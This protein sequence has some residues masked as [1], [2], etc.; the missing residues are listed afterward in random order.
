MKKNYKKAIVHA[1]QLLLIAVIWQLP[2]AIMGSSKSMVVQEDIL[3]TSRG[4]PFPLD[5]DQ[6]PV[7]LTVNNDTAYTSPVQEI[8]V[9]VTVNDLLTCSDY[10]VNIV[11][12]L[13]SIPGT[14]IVSGDYIVFTPAVG[15][16]NQWI[17]IEYSIECNSVTRNAYLSIFVSEYNTPLNVVSQHAECI[18]T[19]PNSVTFGIQRKFRTE[20]GSPASGY[21]IDGFTSP[22]VGDL[23]GDGK[24]EIVMLGVA[25][26]YGGLARNAARYINIYNGQ[27]GTRLY[28]YDLGAKYNQSSKTGYHRPVSAL[29][30]ADV[31][32]DGIGEIIYTRPDGAVLC[33]KPI[34]SGT[35]IIGMLQMWRGNA[36]GT[37]VSAK[38]PLTSASVFQVPAPYIAD[39]N[40]DGIPEVIVYNKV[41]NAKTGALLMAWQGM[42]AS[43]ITSNYT[44]ASGLA[45]NSYS[46]PTIHANATNVRNVAMTGRRPGNGTYADEFVS[47]PAVWDIDG[48][49]QAEIITGNRI[50]KIQINSLTNHTLNTYITIEGP[51]YVDLPEGVSG[52]S[53][54]IY[55]SDGHTRVVDIDGD[56]YL[57]IVVVSYVN[58]GSLDVKVL[59]YVWDPR[60]PSEVK[61]AITYYSDGAHGNISIPFV[62][63]INGKMDGWDGSGYTKKL[64][65][66]CILTGAVQ[67][68]SK[69]SS[70]QTSGRTGIL[71]HP[72]SD[73]LLRQGTAGNRGMDAG[74]D[75]NQT[76]NS[77]RRFNRCYSSKSL[78]GHIIGLTYDAQAIYVYERLKLSWGMEH[79]DRSHQTGITLFDFDNDGAKD[80]CY[81][82]ETTLRVISPKRGNN[83]AGPYGGGSGYTTLSETTSTAGTSIMFSTPIFGGTGFEYPTIADVNL[84]GSANILVTQSANKQDIDGSRGFI[85]VYEYSGVK[86]APAPPVWNQ[87]MYY[88][89]QINEDLT[90]PAR[91]QS[92]LTKYFDGTDSITPFNGSWI[93][94]P[95]VQEG[96]DYK[97]VYRIPDAVITD[98]SIS[99]GVTTAVVTV[100]IRNEG[101]ASLN[102]NTP[103]S[104]Y[105]NNTGTTLA[106]ATYI[107]STTLGV[108]VFPNEK[109]TRTYTIN[110][111][112]SGVLV[113]LQIMDN[114]NKVVPA[115]NYSDCNPDN[116]AWSATDCPYLE[117]TISMNPSNTICGPDGTVLLTA[118]YTGSNPPANRDSA[119]FQ[120]YKNE[121]IIPGAIYPIYAATEAGDYRC[122]VIENIC[123]SF[124]ENTVTVIRSNEVNGEKP[125]ITT[126][127]ANLT[128][129]CGDDGVVILQLK[130]NTYSNNVTYQWFKDGIQLI[131]NPN[132]NKDLI[133][134]S[135]TG[136][137]YLHV[138][139]GGCSI[140]S[141]T[142]HVSSKTDG[143]DKV[144]VKRS[145]TQG[146]IC[147]DGGSIYLY[148]ENTMD[149]INPMYIWLRNDTV[150]HS[151]DAGF[152][153]E[154]TQ[155][156]TYSVLIMSG[157]CSVESSGIT[158]Q[159]SN[160]IIPTP[161]IESVTGSVS[162]CDPSG[163]VVLQLAN[164]S[165]FSGITGYQWY[166]NNIAITGANASNYKAQDSGSYC[167]QV[168]ISGSCAAMSDFL[169]VKEITSSMQ[170]PVVVKDPINGQICGDSSSV[171]LRVDNTT[172]FA[173]G[174][175]Y[176][177]YYGNDIVAE[178]IDMKSYEAK[179]TGNYYLQVT[180]GNCA[181]LSAVISITLSPYE[182]LH[183]PHISA[184]PVSAEICASDGVVEL[185]FTNSFNF[186]SGTYTYQWYKN[187][188]AIV[189][190]ASGIKYYVGQEGAYR[191]KVSSGTCASYSSVIN[192]VKSTSGNTIVKPL[193]E[194][195]PVNAEFIC[196]DGGRILMTVS[197]TTY[198]TGTELVWYHGTDIV[199]QDTSYSYMAV[200]PGTYCVMVLE[201]S[202]ASISQTVTLKGQIGTI[203]PPEIASTSGSNS[204]CIG[205][206]LVLEVTNFYS[207]N[208]VY[209]WFKDDKIIVGETKS[210]LLVTKIGKYR[211]MI[212][213]GSCSSISD[214]AFE[215]VLGTQSI[216]H[217]V[218]VKVPEIN[219]VCIDGDIRLNVFNSQTFSA[220]ATYS[221]YQD[222]IM[223]QNS[224]DP[225]YIASDAGRYYVH[226]ID[227]SCSSTSDEDTL[228]MSTKQIYLPEINY[229]PQ[230][231]TV[232]GDTGV[233]VLK[234]K[235]TSNYSSAVTYQW[236]RNNILLPE[237]TKATISVKD[238]GDYYV[239]VIDG[240]CA[241]TFSS[242]IYVYKENT[243]INKPILDVRPVNATIQGSIPVEMTLDNANVYNSPE[244]VWLRGTDTVGTGLS[245]SASVRGA[246][247]LLVI[248]GNCAVWSDTVNVTIDGCPDTDIPKI[249][250]I[251]ISGKT[252]EDGGSVLLYITNDTAYVAPAYEWV[253][254]GTPN[255]A[256]QKTYETIIAGSY[257]VIV[258]DEGC[259]KQ[260]TPI[261]VVPESTNITK[262]L[263]VRRPEAGSLC[264]L[265]GRIILELSNSSV[266]GTTATYKWMKDNY[267]IENATG[268]I[269]EVTEPG[270]YRIAVEEGDCV[271][272]SEIDTI[273]RNFSFINIPNLTKVPQKDSICIGGSIRYE[274]SN[275]N[276]Y[277]A[278]TF[279]WYCADS[280][281]QNGI[282]AY[283]VATREGRYFVQVVDG[284][285][286]ATS[287]KDTLYMSTTSSIIAPQLTY[288]PQSLTICGDTGVVVMK[289][290]D[291]TIYTNNTTYQWYKYGV[292]IAQATNPVYSATDAGEYHL[293]ITEGSCTSVSNMIRVTR[294]SSTIDIPII[295]SN[296]A[297]GN[298]YGSVPVYL[299]IQNEA[300]F[301]NPTYQWYR[302]SRIMM[303]TQKDL[304][305]NVVGKYRLLVT[306]G[307]CSAW[308]N[309]ITLQDTT[310]SVPVGLLIDTTICE[311]TSI[312]LLTHVTHLSINAKAV[313]FRDLLGV[314]PLSST[315]VSPKTTMIYYV[316]FED[317]VTMC[318]SSLYPLTIS[319]NNGHTLTSDL[320]GGI[321]CSGGLFDYIA[322]SSN[323]SVTYQWKRLPDPAINNGDSATGST[324]AISEF[325]TNNSSSNVLVTYEF[326]LTTTDGSC[327]TAS[328]I[329]V[330]VDVLPSGHTTIRT[331][332]SLCYGDTMVSISY[333]TQQ[334]AAMY[335]KI[336][337]QSSALGVGFVPMSQFELLP[338]N[339]VDISVPLTAMPG[340]YAGTMEIRIGT[341]TESHP[342]TMVVS[343]MPTIT[344]IEKEA[345]FCE[346]DVMILTVQ[347]DGG[348][349]SYQWYYEGNPIQ[350][351][352]S[353]TYTENSFL[354]SMEGS[355]YVVIS[356]SCAIIS[357]DVID[358]YANNQITVL[359][360]WED[361]I[362]VDGNG[363]DYVRYQ[364]YKDG[365]PIGSHA[366]EQYYVAPNGLVGTYHVRVFFADGNYLESCPITLN[367]PKVVK[368]ILYP[369]PVKNG[370]SYTIELIR[371]RED[372]Q[373]STV[374]VY[375]AVGKIVDR[376]IME[377]NKINI[378]AM[379]AAG[380]YSVRIIRADGEVIVIRL[381]VE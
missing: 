73:E 11:T 67:I 237:E 186:P 198:A 343:T 133:R 129:V 192:V 114:G 125:V 105:R 205:G 308:S 302:D 246:Y 219:S 112:Y 304:N 8:S 22:L 314:A 274:I 245:Y 28:R 261:D 284:D 361:I 181:T 330:V 366:S 335:Y 358:V 217:P 43:A 276:L 185:T 119:Q 55:L 373:S 325:L 10:I 357:S 323:S 369:S 127:P 88:P 187:N 92:L 255:G 18:D 180:D 47:I 64:P 148:V 220:S 188:E 281:I 83:G 268:K 77:N 58:D 24:P 2:N 183:K 159:K 263:V 252:C 368:N 225:F 249:A 144:S 298:I 313:F 140:L 247:R 376:H 147:A 97:P 98:M 363:Q 291:T 266:Y 306:E 15:F 285:C 377:D 153:Y 355:Y 311:G 294:S 213:D 69:Y 100:T 334:T 21:C 31:D 38:A 239:Q 71:F 82:D 319:V 155:A 154:A 70:T 292:V 61:A 65:E 106:D 352:T 16:H 275:A 23:N 87:G 124:T 130:N 347:A 3:F 269:Y 277:T 60:Y 85:N 290:K 346:G 139:D 196:Q 78:A 258:K 41:F 333:Q 173:V 340:T 337:Y 242:S 25:G 264:G 74:W 117:Y 30:I 300:Q 138:I 381:I 271:A 241:V 101:T 134:V 1:V 143:L 175:L 90:V 320:H 305:T 356:N 236:Y 137:Y 115:V 226:V 327:P 158:L 29:A 380:V 62:G 189:P 359:T 20:N 146:Q 171:I 157:D 103:I 254:N 35:N 135:D 207:N 287:K 93:Q 113:W 344:E 128:R 53:K 364:W 9:D 40:G 54:R 222:G 136:D 324:Q 151:S 211:V 303:G 52:A 318:M 209:Q 244:G 39:I 238:S 331:M 116:N 5:W 63:D 265:N 184:I 26:T 253:Y 350:G 91:P 203:A 19:M 260:S 240:E 49:G 42:A 167:L 280:V 299:A 338:A 110:G 122:Y 84:D 141:D 250:S 234:I 13:A 210:T 176:T 46:S 375:D 231:L 96:R 142:I 267:V 345:Y 66:I 79:S 131:S 36:L 156:G 145:P 326:M 307:N 218:I 251:P 197:N 310:C 348:N 259:E 182:I 169:D 341:C 279:V 50:H 278:P 223:V 166:K 270:Y 214:S 99:V 273:G 152:Y 288:Y 362:L 109:V 17:N 230:S 51:Q 178:S 123:R 296:P 195:V 102:A 164:K 317:T 208:A 150:I 165:D 262:P 342:F 212:T 37:N 59:V 283:Y 57:D 248:D 354:P 6:V 286:S 336:T 367:T 378:Q 235:N 339:Q 190:A 370:K 360:K 289:I 7:E 282:D 372:N 118:T 228:Y 295:A 216:D 243:T 80:L 132:Y 232:C 170:Q 194:T 201:G 81:R 108:D 202:C 45:N 162:I 229:F 86:W 353:S 204:I 161:K 34:F 33:Y 179:K 365:K 297:N 107:F 48:D 14:A 172:P 89:L 233:V 68:N 72:T 32:N 121:V 120:W 272:F 215:I 351:A 160:T 371:T 293:I 206:S 200:A 44:S 193:I 111:S 309:E 224:T 4:Y 329:L 312:D 104:F 328:P 126:V 301:N 149:Y 379:Y 95:I 227:G 191:M 94:Q 163:S 316:R 257:S 322:V 27:D 76:S 56:G 221:W 12:P 315:I 168:I 321:I 256:T 374:E 349:L 199:Q 177:W 75:N 174:C 332:N